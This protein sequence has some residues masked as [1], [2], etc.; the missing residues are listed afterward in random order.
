M[1][2]LSKYSRV[3]AIIQARLTSTRLPRKVLKTINGKPILQHVVE[4]AKM[5]K[6]VDEVVIASPHP[7]PGFEVFIPKG[8]D[9]QD[10]LTRYY[11]AAGHHHADLVVRITSDCPMLEPYWIDFCIDVLFWGHY[12]YVCNRPYCPDGLDVEVFTRHALE[13]AYKYAT[14]PYDREHVTP[15]I[16]ENMRMAEVSGVTAY[17]NIKVSVDTQKDLNLVRRLMRGL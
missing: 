14:K 10:V 13:N 8:C 1:K 11:Q 2:S 9:E 4:R 5:A 6:R 3:A 12:D 15:Y 7:I 16:R 17:P